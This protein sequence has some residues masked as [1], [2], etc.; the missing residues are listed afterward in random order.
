MLAVRLRVGWC[1]SVRMVNVYQRLLCSI[2]ML[3]RVRWEAVESAEEVSERWT[4]FQMGLSLQPLDGE[5]TRLPST[6]AS[7][8][9]LYRTCSA[10]PWRSP[11]RAVSSKGAL[12]Q[13]R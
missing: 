3:G 9:H 5:N 2:S 4:G 6:T 1:E 7:L 11:V 8:Q 13:G 12:R 10:S